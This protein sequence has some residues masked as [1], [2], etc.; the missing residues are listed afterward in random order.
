MTHQHANCLGVNADTSLDDLYLDGAFEQVKTKL[1]EELRKVLA[2]DKSINTEGNVVADYVAHKITANKEAFLL[3][4]TYLNRWYNIN[5]DNIN[6]KDLSAYK[7]DFFGNHSASTI[8]TIISLGQS[9][10]NNLKAKNNHLAYDASL[11][12]ATGKRGLF[13]YL[14]NYRQLFLPYKTNNEWL[15]TNTKAYIVESKS[16]IAEARKIQDTAEGK[17]KYS[18]GVYDK[19]TADNWEYKGM[20]LPL[21]TMSEKGVYV[22]PICPLSLWGLMIAI[23]LMLITGSAQMQN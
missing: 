23:V 13:N 7:F 5:Y 15:K 11:S 16:D 17:S 1:S 18:V 14:E 2:M 21:L 22:T 3:G 8:D 6:V 10:M 4:L 9:G 20:L 12:E 19:I